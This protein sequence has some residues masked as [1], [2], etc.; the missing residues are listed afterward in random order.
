[1]LTSPERRYRSKSYNRKFLNNCMA[2]GVATADSNTFSRI[3]PYATEVWLGVSVGV[4][5]QIANV[6]IWSLV[7]SWGSFKDSS[8]FGG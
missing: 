4:L 8:V 7:W 5:L 3:R 2:I 6:C 1:M